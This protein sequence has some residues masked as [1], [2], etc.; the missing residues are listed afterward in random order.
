MAVCG[1]KLAF[2]GTKL[3]LQHTQHYQQS[4]TPSYA[5]TLRSFPRHTAAHFWQISSHEVRCEIQT[6]HWRSVNKDLSLKLIWLSFVDIEHTNKKI[7]I[8][9]VNHTSIRTLAINLTKYIST[10]QFMTLEPGI[11]AWYCKCISQGI[12]GILKV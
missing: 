7:D 3:P 10:A 11:P 4:L 8:N 5:L 6:N 2:V 9:C 12:V 1:L